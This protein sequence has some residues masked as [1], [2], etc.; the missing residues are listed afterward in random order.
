MNNNR[1]NDW[2]SRMNLLSPEAQ[3]TMCLEQYGVRSIGAW[4]DEQI[5]GDNNNQTI[6]LIS[7]NELQKRMDQGLLV[8]ARHTLNRIKW[9]IVYTM[10]D[11]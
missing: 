10:P 2:L 3:V 6:V 4:Y 11:C 7:L 8:D 1:I 9:V 5:A